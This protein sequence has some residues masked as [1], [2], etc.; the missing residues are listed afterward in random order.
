MSQP[1]E[2]GEAILIQTGLLVVNQSNGKLE[3]Y[4]GP[5]VIGG[6]SSGNIRSM[7]SSLAQVQLAWAQASELTTDAGSPDDVAPQPTAKGA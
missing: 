1:T 6:L 3:M 2:S 4:Q 7:V 5:T